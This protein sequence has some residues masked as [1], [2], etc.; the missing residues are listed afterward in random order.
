MPTPL[1]PVPQVQPF[2]DIVWLYE[3]KRDG[4]RALA[5]IEEGQCRVF[6][7]NKHRLTAFPHVA[8]A[9]VKEL[10]VDNA[11]LGGELVATDALGRTVFTVLMH[12]SE[13]PDTLPLTC[14]G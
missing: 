5:V 10:K 9:I 7:K 11:I 13:K 14:C 2:D 8:E 3:I 1:R 6:S 4:F 12:R